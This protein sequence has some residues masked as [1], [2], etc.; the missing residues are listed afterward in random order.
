MNFFFKKERKK[1]YGRRKS[2]RAQCGYSM[3]G[4]GVSVTVQLEIRERMKVFML[5][6]E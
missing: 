2:E 1:K 3:L 4:K 5:I 6:Y